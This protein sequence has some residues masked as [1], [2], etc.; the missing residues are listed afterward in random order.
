MPTGHREIAFEVAVEHHLLSVASYAKAAPANF[1]NVSGRSERF[2][3]T[4]GEGA[5]TPFRVL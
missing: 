5:Q 1:A 2:S 4:F 3:R